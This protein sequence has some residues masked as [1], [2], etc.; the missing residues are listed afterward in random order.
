[1]QGRLTF[2][3]LLLFCFLASFICNSAS[4][5]IDLQCDGRDMHSVYLIDNSGFYRIDSVDSAPTNPVFVAPNPLNFIGISINNN[6][7]S[8]TGQET[9]YSVSST[10]YYYYYWNGTGWTNTFSNTGSNLAVNPGGTANYIF[11]LDGTG[12]IY[13]YDGNGNGT[14]LISN[15]PTNN[16]SIFDIATDS[17]GNFYLFYTNSQ[18]IIAYNPAGIPVDSFTTTGFLPGT[19][20]GFAFLADRMYALACGAIYYGLYE[21][22][23]T[24]TNI[25]FT[26]VKPLT[27]FY[28]DIATCHSAAFPLA[29][30][31][32]PEMPHFILYPNPA[33][34]NVII[35][36]NNTALLEISDCTGILK[37]T[38]RT[39]GLT[40]YRLD[41]SKWKAGVYFINV[42]SAKKASARAKLV[43]Q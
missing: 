6:L 35:K 37:E 41:V 28:G 25:H 19:H 14:L 15:L 22:I 7:D 17:S 23:K 27:T 10:N 3:A 1:M 36:L 40:E 21:G 30:F 4:A 34:D 31:K 32:N 18:K 16:T 29:V 43:V 24:G 12:S 38:I 20:C 42:V 13:R 2:T 8:M 26:L 5:Q 39:C 9:M 33:W 11:N